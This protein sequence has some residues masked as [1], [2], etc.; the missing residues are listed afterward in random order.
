MGITGEV[1]AYMFDSA[2]QAFGTA[3]TNELQGIEGKNKKEIERKQ[4]R[5][6]RKWLPDLGEGKP[7]FKDPAQKVVL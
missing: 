1:R 3:L 2:I 5:T 4:E 6:L 7:K